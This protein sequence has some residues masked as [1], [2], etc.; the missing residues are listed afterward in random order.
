MSLTKDPIEELL[1]PENLSR[2]SKL[3]DA[4]PV[5]EKVTDKFVEMD[6]KGQVDMMMSLFDQTISII[7]AV[8][9]ADL[10]NAIISFGM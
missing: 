4:L 7:D 10:I 5:I 6:R 2:L 1:K 8:Q 3:L 9:K